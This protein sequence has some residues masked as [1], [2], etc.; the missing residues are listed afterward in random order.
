MVEQMLHWHGVAH[1]L[2]WVAL[3][4]FNAAG[5]ALDARIGEDSAI[6]LNLIPLALR[7]ALGQTPAVRIFGTDYPT[8][9]GTAIRD[10]VHVVDLADAH[11]RALRYLERGGESLV[12]NLGTG[13]G[14]SVFDVLQR[15]RQA[16]D[17]D[18]P[19]ELEDRRCGDPAAVYADNARARQV[20]GWRPKLTLED[21]VESAWLWSSTH[22]DGY[23]SRDQAT[24]EYVKWP[25]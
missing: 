7:A 24:E 21:I 14:S 9:D 6:S 3:R 18:F 15:V 20:L 16:A 25:A 12:L 23:Q 19:I 22:P 2:R 1:G 10:Y 11:V 5:A 4:Y 8:P 17:V 13:T